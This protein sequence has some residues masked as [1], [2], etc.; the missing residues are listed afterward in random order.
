MRKL[1]ETLP[2]INQYDMT[3][4]W[5]FKNNRLHPKL[6][7]EQNHIP[8]KLRRIIIDFTPDC[9]SATGTVTIFSVFTEFEKSN[10]PVIDFAGHGFNAFET[11]TTAMNNY[12]DFVKQTV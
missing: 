9:K 3:F 4:S 10:E 12:L 6:Q 1:A 8:G 11:A 5:V 7:L 2:T